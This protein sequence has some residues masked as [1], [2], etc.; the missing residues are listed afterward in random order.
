MIGCYDVHVI[1]EWCFYH[2]IGYLL[3]YLYGRRG[4]DLDDVILT[5]ITKINSRSVA[6][7]NMVGVFDVC[8]INGII[9]K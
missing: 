1:R 2:V 4:P 8:M 3:G 5:T 7:S 9:G 6:R